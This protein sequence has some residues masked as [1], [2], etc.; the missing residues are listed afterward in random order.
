MK[1]SYK[2]KE[3]HW[4]IQCL[5]FHVRKVWE[6]ECLLGA[7]SILKEHHSSLFTMSVIS[8]NLNLI[9]GSDGATVFVDII[10][11]ITWFQETLR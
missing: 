10:P 9:L 5:H 8:S 3:I 1:T 6:K 4:N 7:Y 2:I 11:F